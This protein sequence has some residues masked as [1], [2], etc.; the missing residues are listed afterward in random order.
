MKVKKYRKCSVCQSTEHR[1]DFHGSARD[2]ATREADPMPPDIAMRTMLDPFYALW[3]VCDGAVGEALANCTRALSQARIN[4]GGTRIGL[5][6]G[7][8]MLVALA[9]LEQRSRQLDPAQVALVRELRRKKDEADVAYMVAA[10]K[11]TEQLGY[12]PRT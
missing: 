12:P 6:A 9:E 4:N 7:D 3:L 2:R 11:I 10:R 5:S 1:A 8:T